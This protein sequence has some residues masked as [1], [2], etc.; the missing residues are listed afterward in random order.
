MNPNQIS[1]PMVLKQTWTRAVR[2][3]TRGRPMAARSA[4]THV[5]MLAPRARA[6]PVFDVDEPLSRH[7]DDHGGRRGG[8][9]HE[10][11]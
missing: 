7:R 5:P 4:V 9:L 1:T 8:A 11:R 10:C 3:A 2:S 6:M